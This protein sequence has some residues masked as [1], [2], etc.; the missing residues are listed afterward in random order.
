MGLERSSKS[1]LE[2]KEKEEDFSP[3]CFFVSALALFGLCL[4]ELVKNLES[5]F[6]VEEESG[7]K[8]EE[9]KK[10]FKLRKKPGK[11]ALKH[12]VFGFLDGLIEKISLE[13]KETFLTTSKAKNVE[14]IV[15]ETG[16]ER[17]MVLELREKDI[18]FGQKEVLDLC[19]DW[20]LEK[21]SKQKEKEK[22]R[23]L[24][25][26]RHKFL[27]EEDWKT[28]CEKKIFGKKNFVE[29]RRGSNGTKFLEE[30]VSDEA[31]EKLSKEEKKIL[32]EEAKKWIEENLN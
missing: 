10:K 11:R 18:E 26:C 24:V 6:V 23:S 21:F 22:R 3:K 17:R 19:E 1:K 16:N 2:L 7:R 5:E 27:R 31:V 28:I 8:E 20:F 15:A 4:E 25:W 30:V 13:A 29:W 12:F 9:K 32:V 14:T